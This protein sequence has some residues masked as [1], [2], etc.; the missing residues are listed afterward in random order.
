MR[1]GLW[2][3]VLIVAAGITI[4]V[5]L[6][7]FDSKRAYSIE[8]VVLESITFD[9][10]SDAEPSPSD[11]VMPYFMPIERIGKILPETPSVSSEAT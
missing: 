5:T 9:T 4:I 1:S 11:L 3:C 10:E 2:P 8:P 7:R 6:A